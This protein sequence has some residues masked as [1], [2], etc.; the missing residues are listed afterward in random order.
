MTSASL[1]PRPRLRAARPDDSDAIARLHA[2][3]WRRT[4]RGVYADAYL[5][6]DLVA[7]RRAVWTERLTAVPA[8]GVTILA[9]GADGAGDPPELVGFVHVVLDHDGSRGSLVDNL[10]VTHARRGSGVGRLLLNRAAEAVA[11][12]AAGPGLH[13]WVQEQ[14]VAAQGF[15]LA[16]GA[17]TVETVPIAPPGGVPER[18]T[19]RPRK[20]RMVWDDVAAVGSWR[21][22]RGAAPRSH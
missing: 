16:M 4:Y 13:L 3:S 21:G 12:R 8:H 20:I 7:D 17:T 11:E 9:E 18:L 14:N 15:Y 19:G 10:H 22:Q 5:D 1:R 6:G 2:D